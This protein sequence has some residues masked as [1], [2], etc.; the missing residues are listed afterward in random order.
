MRLIDEQYTAY[1]FSGSR[2]MTKWLTQRGEPVNRKR[3]R[4]CGGQ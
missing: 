1:P 2:R 4:G 3:V